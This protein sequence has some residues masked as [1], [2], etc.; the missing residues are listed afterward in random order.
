MMG[1]YAPLVHRVDDRTDPPETRRME[2]MSDA[3]LL[4]VISA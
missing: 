3:E 2:P 1:Y 4:S